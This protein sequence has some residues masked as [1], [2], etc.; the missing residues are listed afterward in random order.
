MR[1][2]VGSN[3]EKS[4]PQDLLSEGLFVQNYKDVILG[5]DD[6]SFRSLAGPGPLPGVRPRDLLPREG[7]IVSRGE[8]HLCRLPRADRVLEL[9]TPPGRA[10]RS[11]GRDER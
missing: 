3:R 6:A 2:C 9:R 10:V 11:V 8:T 5:R 7:R 4:P 1:W